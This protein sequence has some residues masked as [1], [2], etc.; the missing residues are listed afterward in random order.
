MEN[1]T[2]PVCKGRRYFVFRGI[3]NRLCLKCNGIG[4][5]LKEKK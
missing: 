1:K 4:I 3:G 2:C 5:I